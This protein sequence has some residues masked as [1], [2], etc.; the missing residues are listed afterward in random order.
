MLAEIFL[1]S[2]QESVTR[3][4]GYWDPE[5]EDLQ[6]RRQ[7]E[8][9]GTRVLQVDDEDVGFITTRRLTAAT[10]EVHTLCVAPRV[11]GRGI[12]SSVIRELTRA[13]D[14]DGTELELSVLKENPR[15]RQFY[16]RLGFVE[17][18]R[19]E[20]HVRMRRPRPA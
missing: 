6:F 16:E 15:A 10:T 8:L 2:M 20:H 17:I 12:G 1:T 13:A 4:R 3:A 11:Q 5:K 19:S 9:G 14:R 7:L 18:G